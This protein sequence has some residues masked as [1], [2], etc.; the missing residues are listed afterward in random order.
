MGSRAALLSPDD[1][2]GFLNKIFS[3]FD[4]LAEIHGLEK[5]KTIGDAY[6]AAAG[7][8]SPVHDPTHRVA[9]MA[10]DMQLTV[11]A[12]SRDFPTGLNDYR[13]T[14]VGS[15]MWFSRYCNTTSSMMAPLVVE[16]YPR[17]QNRRPQ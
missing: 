17:P 2:V 15:A 6:M 7:M 9:E 10:L 12:M 1:L 3:A 5:I 13:L 16:K 8:P 14:S 11:E 4:E